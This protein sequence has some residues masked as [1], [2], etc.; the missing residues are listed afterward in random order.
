MK[1][2]RPCPQCGVWTCDDCG[3]KRHNANL[4]QPGKQFCHRCK[5]TIGTMK[6]T[7]H[8]WTHTHLHER[9]GW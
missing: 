6:P 5:C 2:T 3:W 9:D 4:S 7:Q 8:R 1:I